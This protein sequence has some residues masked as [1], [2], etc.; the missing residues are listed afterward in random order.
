MFD[1]V[2]GNMDSLG[3]WSRSSCAYAI[4]HE[5]SSLMNVSSTSSSASVK[6]NVRNVSFHCAGSV[7]LKPHRSNTS[8]LSSSSAYKGVATAVL[9]SCFAG[10]GGVAPGSICCAFL[11]VS[12]LY[13]RPK[14][15]PTAKS[16]EK[17]ISTAIALDRSAPPQYGAC[18]AFESHQLVLVLKYQIF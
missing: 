18:H 15:I 9:V 14:A 11:R 12:S 17:P 10:A 3:I 4:T 1:A 6:E 8:A 13:V 2:R 16:R 5:V 7:T